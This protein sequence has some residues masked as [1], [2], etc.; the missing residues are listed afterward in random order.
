MI[1]LYFQCQEITTIGQH[2]VS[3][4]PSAVDLSF[5]VASTQKI[6]ALFCRINFDYVANFVKNVFLSIF[7]FEYKKR[8][9]I[10]IKIYFFSIVIYFVNFMNFHF[11]F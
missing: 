11:I 9:K 1:I 8:K 7:S 6:E 5:I 3:L 4:R 10:H 2:K